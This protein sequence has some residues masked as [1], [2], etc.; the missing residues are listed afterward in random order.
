MSEHNLRHQL[1]NL[2]PVFD[3][4]ELIEQL[5]EKGTRMDISPETELLQ[6]GSY[7][8]VIP[9]V[10]QGNIKV[11]REDDS[12]REVFLYFI[13]PGQ[14]CAF[15]LASAL[16]A[17]KSKIRAITQEET[18]VLAIPSEELG[19][20]G[21]HFPS[22]VHFMVETF[23]NRFDELLHTLEGVVFHSLDERLFQYLLHQ[24]QT[25]NSRVLPLS[26]QQIADD[27]AT[28]REVISRLLKQMEKRG[29]LRL[30]RGQIL[31]RKSALQDK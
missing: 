10:I 7:I 14:S 20:L 6:A 16:R 4:L 30:N 26:H 24:A 3:Q 2:F 22:W 9:L 29:L 27:L 23:S 13:Q 11:I 19:P 18:T 15:T 17:E 25:R 28:S 12:G 31:L 8:R 5:L 21:R 1:A